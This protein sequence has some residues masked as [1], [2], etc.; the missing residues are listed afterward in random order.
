MGTN[1]KLLNYKQSLKLRPL[2]RDFYDFITDYLGLLDLSTKSP[3]INAF[4]PWFGLSNDRI[5]P[6][7]YSQYMDGRIHQKYRIALEFCAIQAGLSS[8]VGY[9]ESKKRLR[10]ATTCRFWF[11]GRHPYIVKWIMRGAGEDKT[12]I[13]FEGEE[14][15]GSI[16]IDTIEDWL[17]EHIS[18][19]RDVQNE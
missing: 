3:M 10:P 11:H 2:S 4:D 12:K 5:R 18:K 19:F 8:V 7:D 15:Q 16:N 14:K 13:I 1:E 6:D 9:V 17:A